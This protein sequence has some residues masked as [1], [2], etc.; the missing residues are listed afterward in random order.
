MKDP[1]LVDL[2]TKVGCQEGLPVVW[3]AFRI[4]VRNN[5]KQI[6]LILFFRLLNFIPVMGSVILIVLIFII[7]AYYFGC[8]FMDY[9]YERW[10]LSYNSY[11]L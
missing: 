9:T 5:I 11:I 2:S 1:L 8:S 4:E 3:R 7:S 10:R 6:S